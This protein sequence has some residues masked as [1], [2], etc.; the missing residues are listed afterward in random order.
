[1]LVVQAVLFT[2]A[3]SQS[4][5]S[6]AGQSP[7]R[8]GQTIALDLANL[9]DRDSQA[10]LVQYVHDQYAQYNH[11][12]FVVLADGRVIPSGSGKISEPLLAIAR[13]QLL[14]WAEPPPV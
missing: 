13:A 9:L 12:F 10:D 5:R 6:L 2:W 8:F 1:M 3:V 4:G 11:P 14:K 7:I